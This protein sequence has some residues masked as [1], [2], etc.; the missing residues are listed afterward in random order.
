MNRKSIEKSIGKSLLKMKLETKESLSHKIGEHINNL[1]ESGPIGI[2]CDD[3]LESQPQV[4]Y[5]LHMLLIN[6]KM[7]LQYND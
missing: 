3:F 7:K 5:K 2:F 6:Y 1:P 4:D